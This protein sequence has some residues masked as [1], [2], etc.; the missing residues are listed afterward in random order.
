MKTE[1]VVY[2]VAEIEK[3]LGISKSKAYTLVHK[4]WKEGVPFRVIKVGEEYRIPKKQFEQWVG[5]E[6]DEKEIKR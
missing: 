1:K 3:M 5:F 4:A 6:V 2:T